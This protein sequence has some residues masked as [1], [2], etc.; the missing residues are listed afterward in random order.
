MG[1]RLRGQTLAYQGIRHQGGSANLTLM[2]QRKVPA[3]PKDLSSQL[4][5][6]QWALERGAWEEARQRF[7]AAVKEEEHPEAFEG[8]GA[9]AWW[10]Q[11]PAVALEARERAYRLFRERGNQ[12]GAAR[13]ATELGFDYATIRFQLAVSAG[14]LQRAHRLLAGTDSCPERA[15]L[16]LREAELAYHTTFDLNRVRRLAIEAQEHGAHLGSADLEMM[17][18]ALEGLAQVGLGE[19][20]DGMRRVDEASAAA[21]AGDMKSFQT[22]ASTLCFMIWACERVRDVSRASEWCDYLLQY[23]GRSALRDHLAFCRGHY[24]SVLIARGHWDEAADELEHALTVLGHRRAWTLTLHERLG[25]LRRRQGRLEDAERSF[26][27]SQPSRAGVLGAARVALERGDIEAALDVVERLLRQL[28]EENLGDH[29]APLELLVSV[30]CVSGDDDRAAEAVD[31]LAAVAGKFDTECVKA[32]VSYKRGQVAMAAG[33]FGAAKVHMEDALDLYQRHQLP[34]EA[35]HVRLELARA[36]LGCG[37]PEAAEDQGRKAQEL[38]EELGASAAVA[39]ALD[40]I[41]EVRGSRGGTDLTLRELEV[42]RLLAQGL[43]NQQIA[44][45]LSLSLHTVRRHVSNILMKLDLPSRTAAAAYALK[46]GFA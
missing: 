42:L 18:L 24:A 7:T 40:L 11:D 37:R 41:D 9:A 31:A 1:L 13:M 23:C 25:E 20:S 5:E 16:A 33:R 38:L 22:V 46:H 36:L 45:E 27:R 21:V 32:L 10:L 14:W 19:V 17:G 15:W 6:A 8:L 12:L 44:D 2:E 35:A 39:T 29:I 28:P 34:F 43:R 30:H 26:E 3:Q 4:H